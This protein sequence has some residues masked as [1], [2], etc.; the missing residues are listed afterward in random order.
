MAGQERLFSTRAESLQRKIEQLH[1]RRIQIEDQIRG[2]E[3]QQRSLKIQLDLFADELRD[4][5][6]LLDK[7]LAQ[8]SRVLALRR[9]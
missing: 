7:G 2:I 6:E 3:A 5:Q 4:Q 9:Q 8:A 1:K